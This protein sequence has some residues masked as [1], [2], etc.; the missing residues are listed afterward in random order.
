MMPFVL[1]KGS[2]RKIDSDPMHYVSKTSKDIPYWRMPRTNG[3][4]YSK[5]DLRNMGYETQ[6][7]S[8]GDW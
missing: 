6:D 8:H 5:D 3:V 4:R 1:F 7:V 2:G